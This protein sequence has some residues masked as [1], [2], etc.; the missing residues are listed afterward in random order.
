MP[1]PV[2]GGSSSL[3]FQEARES[4]RNPKDHDSKKSVSQNNDSA[5]QKSRT[6]HGHSGAGQKS[7]IHRTAREGMRLRASHVSVLR[8]H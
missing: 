5:R 3:D 2:D 4:R 7:R 8:S 6:C 1:P